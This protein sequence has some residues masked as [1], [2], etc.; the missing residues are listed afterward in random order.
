MGAFFMK[1][2][3]YILFLGLCFSTKAQ[4]NLVPNPSFEDTIPCN[5]TI[6][7]PVVNWTVTYGS[8]DYFNSV[9][10]SLCGTNCM[11]VPYNFWSYQQPLDGNAYMGFDNYCLPG[12]CGANYREWM[13]AQLL[14]TMITNK[15][16]CVSFFVNL[17]HNCDYATDDIGAALTVSP[18]VPLG[19][20]NQINNL[21]GNFITDTV[22]WT[23]ITGVMTA[24]GGEKYITIGNFKNDA[25]TT[26]ISNN[27]ASGVPE[28][29]YFAD[30]VSVYQLPDIDAGN[31]DTICLGDTVHL[32]ASY[33]GGWPGLKYRWFPS[34]GLSDTTILNPVA[35][36][37]IST[38]YYFGLIDTTGTIPGM[39]NYYDSVKVLVSCVGIDE[40]GNKKDAGMYPNPANTKAYYEMELSS[41]E[42]GFVQ[43]YDLLGNIVASQ[44]LN[45]GQNKA[46]FDLTE[47]ASGLYVYKVIINNEFRTSNKLIITK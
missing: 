42:T 39:I 25:G 34:G 17:T 40:Y 5:A 33:T 24:V 43:L 21:S 32:N 47:L 38:T 11:N 37:T 18:T 4:I 16:Y 20:S 9:Y 10:Y 46:V 28:T 45:A 35:T 15:K 36:P 7:F 6:T 8:P 23:L 3:I 22:N 29:Y 26:V 14:S 41:D 44:K 19:Y 12:S 27:P 30:M 13:Q 2:I 31:P 1:K